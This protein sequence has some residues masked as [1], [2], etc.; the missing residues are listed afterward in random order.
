MSVDL[1]AGNL[2]TFYLSA[3]NSAA[4]RALGIKSTRIFIGG[5]PEYVCW[6]REK[7][8]KAVQDWKVS[9]N[10]VLRKKCDPIAKWEERE[11][12]PDFAE[13]LGWNGHGTL[14]LAAMLDERRGASVPEEATASPSSHPEWDRWQEKIA[15][16]PYL[17]LVMPDLWVPGSFDPV[18]M[19][20]NPVDQDA[21]VGGTGRLLN[22]LRTLDQ[23]HKA[24][25]KDAPRTPFLEIA[26]DMI[27]RALRL[28]T[29]ANEHELPVVLST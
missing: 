1:F 8:Q 18:L 14:R 28:V 12:A 23:R 5:E 9:L 16:S 24:R 25:F 3:W 27:E 4:G 11:N 29:L 19:Y 20:W 21:V 17:H 22:A 6:P 2:T 13:Q 26:E 15:D 7:M 10:A